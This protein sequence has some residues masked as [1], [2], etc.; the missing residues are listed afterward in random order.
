VV[1]GSPIEGIIPKL[2]SLTFQLKIQPYQSQ[3]TQIKKFKEYNE[4][5][6]YFNE[7]PRVPSNNYKHNNNDDAVTTSKI[8]LD[9]VVVLDNNQRINLY[10]NRFTR[11]YAI[12]AN[13]IHLVRAAT[14]FEE[15]LKILDGIFKVSKERELLNSVDNPG[16]N[17]GWQTSRRSR[18]YIHLNQFEHEELILRLL[19]RQ[20]KLIKQTHRE[21]AVNLLKNFKPNVILCFFV[22][23]GGSLR[24]H[25]NEKT[26][27]QPWVAIFN[28]G[29]TLTYT[30]KAYKNKTEDKLQT[31]EEVRN[32]EYEFN[33][34]SQDFVI[35]DGVKVP[36]GYKECK[37]TSFT[38]EGKVPFYFSQ[39]GITDPFR[40]GVVLM[41]FVNL[42]DLPNYFYHGAAHTEP[43]YPFIV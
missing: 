21:F 16:F 3:T 1:I 25:I 4:A 19:R 8:K 42:S 6:K 30:V 43:L 18:M 14:S 28:F 34:K 31:R 24:S 37:K 36:H 23:P 20:L 2:D 13:Y 35:F 5:L 12:Q 29:C 40:L 38:C 26:S 11:H 39:Y 27:D 22:E 41:Q 10:R 7:Y 15:S 33:F 9:K 17:L 32:S